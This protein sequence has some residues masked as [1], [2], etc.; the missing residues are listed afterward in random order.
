M[1]LFAFCPPHPDYDAALQLLFPPLS[2]VSSESIADSLFLLFHSGMGPIPRCLPFQSKDPVN[3]FSPPAL[4]LGSFFHPHQLMT[5][6]PLKCPCPLVQRP[7]RL[8]IGP[9]K[10]LPPFAPHMHQ[11]NIP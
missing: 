3:P 6:E 4:L 9:V 8:R 1:D 11:P 7:N 2:R 10:H 5:P